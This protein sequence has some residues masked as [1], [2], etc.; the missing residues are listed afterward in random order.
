MRKRSLP[1]R[2]SA[3]NTIGGVLLGYAAIML[4]AT[5]VSML[6]SRGYSLIISGLGDLLAPFDKNLLPDAIDESGPGYVL[7]ALLVVLTIRLWK[8]QGY[9]PQAM[10]KQGSMSLPAFLGSLGVF[11]SVQTVSGIL[12]SYAESILNHWGLTSMHAQL[13]ASGQSST[14]SMFL[15]VG[16]LAPIVEELM[17]RGA[18][19]DTL[20][21]F[22][23]RFA[24]VSSAL[25]FGL[26]HGNLIQIPFAFLVGLVLAYVRSEYGMI[27]CIAL[28][29][30][31]NC[32]LV[33]ILSAYEAASSIVLVACF[34]VAVLAL[35]LRG[36]HLRHQL[37]AIP[38][39]DQGAYR[40]LFANPLTIVL[41]IYCLLS[42]LVTITPLSAA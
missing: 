41:M 20:L 15:Y 33:E 6:F 17:F 26:F 31:N 27:W 37:K 11:M 7:S 32:I 9:L 23:R 36:N 28:H 5:T 39:T 3:C 18:I 4:V 14:L 34:V 29:F 16:I 42:T 38:A 12:I 22:G 30:I 2:K 1:A 24:M 8:G 10:K 21:P 40:D 35:T 19:F 13:Q 25:L